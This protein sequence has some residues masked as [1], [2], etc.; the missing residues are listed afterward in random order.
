MIVGLTLVGI[1]GAILLPLLWWA[2]C[3]KADLFKDS[4]SDVAG[5]FGFFWQFFFLGLAFILYCVLVGTVVFKKLQGKCKLPQILFHL[6]FLP[7]FGTMVIPYDKQGQG[8]LSWIGNTNT[9]VLLGDIHNGLAYASTALLI[10]SMVVLQVLLFLRYQNK[11]FA[12]VSS[13]TLVVVVAVAVRLIN[14]H[15]TCSIAE[16]IALGYVTTH[17]FVCNLFVNANALRVKVAK[18][19]MLSAK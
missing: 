3:S 18:R 13:S 5:K 15:G 12:I 8:T 17:L 4:V 11:L 7:Y 14:L 9:T 2:Y 10:L 16:C 19:Y 1:I 6:S